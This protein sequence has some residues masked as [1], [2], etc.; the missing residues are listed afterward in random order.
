MTRNEVSNVSQSEGGMF[1]VIPSVVMKDKDLPMSA[2]MLYGIITWKCNDL[3][4]CWATNRALGAELD[5]SPK[6][7]SALLSLLEQQGHIET[8]IERDRASG[9]ILKR[10][11]FPIVKSSRGVFEVLHKGG[12]Y[13]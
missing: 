9:Q 3:A 8:D 13:P 12:A 5:L 7:V 1:A 10:Y 6:R 2:K 4:Y 11:I